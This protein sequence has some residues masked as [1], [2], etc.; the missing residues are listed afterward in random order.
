MPINCTSSK[1]DDKQTRKTARCD[2]KK[3]NLNPELKIF[4][5]INKEDLFL[6]GFLQQKSKVEHTMWTKMTLDCQV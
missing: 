5:H 2:F 3:M 4:V 1:Y 6:N